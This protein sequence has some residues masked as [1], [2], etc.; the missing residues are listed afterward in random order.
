MGQTDSRKIDLD[1]GKTISQI[2]D[3]YGYGDS[4]HAFESLYIWSRD[5]TLSI[6]L[7]D[8]IYA[9]RLDKSGPNTWF[10][11]VGSTEQKK[12]FVSKKL[13]SG[14]LVFRYM[15]KEDVAFLDDNFQGRFEID[16]APG[17]SEYVY[18]R[19]T[20]ENLPGKGLSRKRRYVAKLTREHSF[21]V[22]KLGKD[23]MAD[24]R[25]I[26]GVWRKNKDNELECNDLGA[27]EVMMLS[28][29]QLS[30]E[31]IVVYMDGLPCSVAAGYLLTEDTVDAC[32]QKSTVNLHGLQYHVRQLFSAYWPESVKFYNYEEDLGIEGL[33]TAKEFMHPCSMV[34][35]YKG[36][37][38]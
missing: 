9:A 7:A 14:D 18:D 36:R 8:D 16:S 3:K 33:K 20:I 38:I 4:A 17:D 5:M 15:T 35:M 19:D 32:L 2:Y 26:L 29:S 21:E 24:V 34:D 25:Y 13:A 11:P 30:I 1:M 31:G 28:F 10:F 27:L 6:Y 22:K 37:S 23:T 12:A